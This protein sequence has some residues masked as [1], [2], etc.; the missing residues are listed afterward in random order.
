MEERGAE[1][2][3]AYSHNP[4]QDD[5][6]ASD[7]QVNV[8]EEGWAVLCRPPSLIPRVDYISR[9]NGGNEEFGG[10]KTINLIVG[11]LCRT[12]KI[13]SHDWCRNLGTWSAF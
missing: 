9:E 13:F 8:P 11:V 4:I 2:G 12:N 5:D 7:V 1:C 3:G 6:D 10:G